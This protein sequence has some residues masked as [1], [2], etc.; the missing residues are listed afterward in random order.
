M[1]KNNH[2]DSKLNIVTIRLNIIAT[3]EN[4]KNYNFDLEIKSI[5]P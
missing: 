4:K 2:A 1:Y 5:Y 3:I